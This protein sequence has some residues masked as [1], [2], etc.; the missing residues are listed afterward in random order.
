ILLPRLGRGSARTRSAAEPAVRITIPSQPATA[1][2]SAAPIAIAESS[3]PV[4]AARSA[5]AASA[6]APVF[7][8]PNSGGVERLVQPDC[9]QVHAA[10]AI[11]LNDPYVQLIAHLYYVIRASGRWI[12]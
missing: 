3:A 8:R 4:S 12:G 2:R 6:A 5:E 9:A 1:S 10:L 11:D 7:P